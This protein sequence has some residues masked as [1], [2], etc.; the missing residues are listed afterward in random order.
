[1]S[2]K[3][4]D[5]EPEPKPSEVDPEEQCPFGEEQERFDAEM[6]EAQEVATSR[7]KRKAQAAEGDDTPQWVLDMPDDHI[8]E[9]VLA[10]K[11][12]KKARLSPGQLDL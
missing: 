11:G 8:N 12:W 3:P 7:D 2:P 9:A 4:E 1:M 5:K 6:G 10:G